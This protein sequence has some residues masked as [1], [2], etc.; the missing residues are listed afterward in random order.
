MI[1]RFLRRN[2]PQFGT[3][4]VYGSEQRIIARNAQPAKWN[5]QK[6]SQTEEEYIV[7]RQPW[8]TKKVKL[9][10][11]CGVWKHLAQNTVLSL[12]CA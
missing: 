10:N 11:L 3:A 1:V 7:T 2:V 8:P 5:V 4:N 12:E 6:W 9:N